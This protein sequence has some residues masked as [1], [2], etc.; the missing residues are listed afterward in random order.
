MHQLAD[1]FEIVIWRSLRDIPAC[2]QLVT[3]LL[4]VLVPQ[5]LGEVHASFERRQ[6]FLVQYLRNTQVLLVLDN[7]ESVLE[8]GN[9][10]GRMRTGYEDFGR[11]LR[12]CAE[13]AHQSCVLLTSR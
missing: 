2:G 1:R 13:T 11:F 6:S 9:S 10:I 12:Q 4:Q 8:E 7:L 3:D 5:V